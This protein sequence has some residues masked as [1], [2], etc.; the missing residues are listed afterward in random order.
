[1]WSDC[2]GQV[3]ITMPIAQYS[4]QTFPYGAI[5]WVDH[6][7]AGDTLKRLGSERGKIFEGLALIQ[8]SICHKAAKAVDILCHV[9]DKFAFFTYYSWMQTLTPHFIFH[10]NHFIYIHDDLKRWTL[11]IL[12]IYSHCL[13]CTVHICLRPIY[14]VKALQRILVYLNH[15]C[16]THWWRIFTTSMFYVIMLKI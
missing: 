6:T 11:S 15:L 10:K 14:D 3:S 2:T 4:S 16:F 9:N 1:M 13:E 7:S 5:L 12:S 8:E